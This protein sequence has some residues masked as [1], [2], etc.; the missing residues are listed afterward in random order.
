VG[1][2]TSG[3]S[4]LRDIVVAD[5]AGND[6]R[7]A[8]AIALGVSWQTTLLIGRVGSRPIE[9]SGNCKQ[10]WDVVTG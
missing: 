9:T 2:V 5:R 6:E 4:E 1:V 3:E 8:I 7:V 10:R